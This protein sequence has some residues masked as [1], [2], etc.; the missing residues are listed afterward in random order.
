MTNPAVMVSWSKDGGATW[1]RPIARSFG[2]I[3]R[4][5]AK[6]SVNGL[7]RSTAHGLRL[8]C[9]VIDPVPAVLRGAVATTKTSG[10][11]AVEN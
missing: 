8:R 11:R 6:V 1:S 9:D 5:A 4:Y 7:G 3:G 10:P 2:R